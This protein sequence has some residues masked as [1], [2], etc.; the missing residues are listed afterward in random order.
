[1]KFTRGER[2]RERVVLSSN[3]VNMHSHMGCVIVL[4]P[5]LSSF[6]LYKNFLEEGR[7]RVGI[8]ASCNDRREINKRTTYDGKVCVYFFFFLFHADTPS[9]LRELCH[10]YAILRFLEGGMEFIWE[11]SLYLSFYF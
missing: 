7:R 10:Y 8:R 6:S 11:C 5:P 4:L 3:V 2:K 9:L 1:M